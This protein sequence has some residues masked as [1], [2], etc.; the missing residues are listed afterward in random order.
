[1]ASNM[2]FSR[3]K[4]PGVPGI[5]T[6]KGHTF[7]A[8]RWDF[9]YT[10][11]DSTGGLTKLKDKRVAIIGT[12]ATS[13]QVIPHLGEDAQHL[14]VV[15]RTPSIIDVRG[16]RP[17]DPEWWKSLK[18]GWQDE[19]IVNFDLVMEG[20]NPEVDLVND[21]WSV[22]WG[23]P[24]L[25][26][27][28]EAESARL[29]AEYDYRE[30]ERIRKRIGEIVNDPA[31]AESLKP[32]YSRFCKRPCYNDEY[33]QT[34]N[35]PN[36]T[37]LDTDGQGVERITEKGIVCNGV[38][39]E[40][41]CIIFATGF[42]STAKT[43]TQSGQY[44]VVGK[45][46]FSVDDKWGGDDEYFSLHGLCANGFPNLFMLGN[47]RQ[48]AASFNI[49]HRL[50]VQSDHITNV[51]RDLKEQGVQS[52]EPTAESEKEWDQVVKAQSGG[53]KQVATQM[54]ECTPSYY[55]NEGKIGTKRLPII[56]AGFAGGTMK[57]SSIVDEWRTTGGI[58]KDCY[59]RR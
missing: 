19:R 25:Q 27:L 41:D 53:G 6:F 20:R 32:W 47:S 36:V 56:A 14:Y 38:E 7:H 33:L 59:L 28:S 46:G 22:M 26:G 55:N 48:S 2:F 10:G 37:L 4:L 45:D 13:V 52:F 57:W 24:N 3:P 12:G 58:E 30:M 16:N 42:E 54:R 23:R 50:Y 31:T 40:V 39:Y 8:S 51:I 18:P 1:M 5:E 34:F 11:G 15:Q 35:R 17:T 21:Q 29:M 49:P 43:P 44:N 9:D